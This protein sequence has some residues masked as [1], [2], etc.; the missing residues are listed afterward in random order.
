MTQTDFSPARYAGRPLLMEPAFAGEWISDARMPAEGQGLGARLQNLLRSS[1]GRL[2]ADRQFK[3]TASESFGRSDMALANSRIPIIDQIAVIS[4]DMPLMESSWWGCSYQM[5]HAGIS[6]ALADDRVKGI[7]LDVSSPGGVCSS[8]LTDIVSLLAANK[9]DPAGK[10][11]HVFAEMACSAAYWISSQADRITASQMSIIGSIGAVMVHM[12]ES[13]ALGKWGVKVTPIQFGEEKTAGAWFQPLSET[14]RADL[15]AQ[16]DQIGRDFV[17]DVVAGR[18]AM[19]ADMVLGTEARVFLGSHDEPERS[20]KSLGLI[21][22]VGNRQSA[23]ANLNDKIL[24]ADAAVIPGGPAASTA[25]DGDKDMAKKDEFLATLA[26]LQQGIA[27][28]TR[29]VKAADE[30]DFSSEED[31]DDAAAK[32]KAEEDED[33]A[34]KKKAEEDDE[35]AAKKKAED[36]DDM[37]G[38]EGEGEDDDDADDAAAKKKADKKSDAT[39]L[40]ELAYAGLPEANGREGLAKSL[41]RSGVELE[42]AKAILRA[43]ARDGK[44]AG[45]EDVPLGANVPGKGSG[46]QGSGLSAAIVELNKKRAEAKAQQAGR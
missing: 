34:A 18:P 16:V 45:R 33:A 42:A 38:D 43:D 26:G 22:M 44:L 3:F 35:A 31:D 2:D 17:R 25:I 32:K 41:A 30:N 27:A 10:P 20:A 8:G 13:E 7:F 6:E 11:V 24:A 5:L 9:S 23:F 15:Q 14:A 29:Q 21:D 1:T 28:L 37:S 4:I 46:D 19:S 36:G 40:R 12:D 39:V